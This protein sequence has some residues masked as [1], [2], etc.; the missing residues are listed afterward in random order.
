MIGVLAN[1]SEERALREFFELF[2]T[3][4]EFYN[5]DQ[6]YEV[7]ISTRVP[8]ESVK[9]KLLVVYSSSPSA[10]ESAS[11]PIAPSHKGKGIYLE[12]QGKTFAVYGK[13][14]TFESGLE[15]LVR[16]HGASGAVVV[17]SAPIE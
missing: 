12:H 2:K 6:S 7:V 17:E 10:S 1:P 8:L 4:W 14:L 13:V 11:R 9:T 3:P 15:T 5:P 16:L